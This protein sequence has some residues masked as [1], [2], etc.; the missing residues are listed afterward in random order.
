MP[1]QH[2]EPVPGLVADGFHAWPRSVA[3]LLRSLRV[4][5]RVNR[6]VLAPATHPRRDEQFQLI[7]GLRTER[8][9]GLPI[10]SIDSKK[11]ELVGRFKNP[12]AAW[13]QDAEDVFDHDFPSWA[14]GRAVPYGIYDL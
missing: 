9:A 14:S 7:A 13:K 10:V 1:P 5:L 8:D 3:R 6:K 4:S 2:R 11:K 12:G